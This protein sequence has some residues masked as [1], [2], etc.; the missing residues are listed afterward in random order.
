M[1]L[2]LTVAIHVLHIVLCAL[3]EVVIPR[4]D[5]L[6]SRVVLGAL[7]V[8]AGAFVPWGRR[9]TEAAAVAA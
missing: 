9:A 2:L 8:S 1:A 6:T 4:Y 7:L 5:E 3:V